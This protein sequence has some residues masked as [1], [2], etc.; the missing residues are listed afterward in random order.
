MHGIIGSLVLLGKGF[1]QHM[2]VDDLGAAGHGVL[3]PHLSELPNDDLPDALG[4]VHG[5][6]QVGD[7]GLQVVHFLGALQDI[8]L[9]DVAQADVGHKLG[10]DLV[11]SEA[12]HQVGHHLG[13]L[14]GLP[15]DADGPVDVQ[16]DAPQA[17]QQMQLIL[18]L[19]HVVVDPAAHAVHTPGGPL[20][21]NLPHTH[22][23]G[24]AGDEDVEVAGLGIHEGGGP[25]E[26][27]H[28]LVRVGAPLQVNGQF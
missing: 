7:L 19:F 13:V 27:G 3:F 1:L 28:E 21:Q 20:L 4:V 10:L 18:L 16:Q 23:F 12:D 17:F 22:D 11:D 15:D 26:L 2:L 25:E 24:H 5:V 14:L 6:L 8:F 9:I